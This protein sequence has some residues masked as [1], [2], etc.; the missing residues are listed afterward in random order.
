MTHLVVME[1]A[2]KCKSAQKYLGANYEC[3]SSKGHCIDLPKS[4]ISVDIK[5]N[6]EPTYAVMEDKKKDLRAIVEK[7]KTAESVYLFSDPDREGEAIA[8][9]LSKVLPS[10]I[11]FKRVRSSEITKAG[12]K[13]A[14]ENETDI[15]MDLVYA[16]E[17]RRILDRLVGYKCSQPVKMATGGRS[18]GRTQSAGL[19]VLGEREIEIREFIPEEYWDIKGVLL[20]EGKEQVSVSIKT[21]KPI[22]IKTEKDAQTIINSFIKGPVSVSKYTAKVVNVKPKE[23]FKTSTLQ[24]AAS[25]YLGMGAKAAMQVAQKLYESGVISY[26]RTDSVTISPGFVT[27]IREF[28]SS[29]Y[30]NGYLPK[31]AKIYKSKSKNAQEGHE[32]IRPTDL[33]NIPANN[34]D[35][36][37]AKLYNLIWRAAVASQ[38]TNARDERRSAQFTE[39]NYVLSASGNKQ[40]FDGFR[41]VWNV[42]SVSESYLPDMSEGQS[43]EVV[44]LEKEQKET[45]PPSRYS[46]ASFISKME[47]LEI[48]RPATFASLIETLKTRTYIEIGKSRSIT[49]TDLGLTVLAFLRK[50]DFC[51]ID[52]GF[53][54]VMEDKLDLVANGS[55]N[56]VEVLNEFWG[57]LSS[58]LQRSKSLRDEDS[59]TE[60]DCPKCSNETESVKLRKKHSQYGAFYSCSNYPDCKFKAN[61][62]ENGEPVAQVKKEVVI[63][64]YKCPNCNEQM[65][66]RNGKQGVFYGCSK[67]PKCK[68]IRNGDGSNPFDTKYKCQKCQSPMIE[69]KGKWGKFY[70]CSGYPKCRGMRNGDGEEVKPK[71]KT[72]KKK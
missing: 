37:E 23:P 28:I 60:Y 65:V 70:G 13:K 72:K 38:M 33:T 12:V 20:T 50:V 63:S 9:H 43:V 19:R 25:T 6:F 36:P 56:K 2:T 22:D 71:P 45:K 17:T 1:S 34:P 29:N 55:A 57:R 21:P 64:S 4:P 52:L 27:Q 58:D 7:A 8:W 54:A 35:N 39:G 42:S 15:D 51:F 16:Y 41:K 40:V 49:T 61:L 5:N 67:Y 31:S 30:D 69:R 62:G 14:F 66:E 26:H 59:K 3:I 32:A 11:P 47:E 44:T 10:S 48:G 24:K 53:T 68:G 18:A 46:E